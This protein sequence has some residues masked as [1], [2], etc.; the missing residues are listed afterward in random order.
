MIEWKKFFWPTTLDKG[1]TLFQNKRVINITENNDKYT[2]SVL[3]TKRY[4]VSFSI[5]DRKIKGTHC[6]CPMSKGMGLCEHVAA[7]LYT[8]E[9]KKEDMEKQR[10]E[11]ARK[12]AEQ[13]KK[14]A[15]QM[16]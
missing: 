4:E 7:V 3:D 13:Y 16:K 8:V 15:E 14:E 6:Q 9:N 5:R 1:M 2:A 11:E 12:H 10:L